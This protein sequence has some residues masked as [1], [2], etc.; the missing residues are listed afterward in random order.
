MHSRSKHLGSYDFDS[1]VRANKE[2]NEYVQIKHGRKTIDFSNPKGVKALNKALLSHFYKINYWDVPKNYLCPPV[3]G[4]A[5]YV[6]YV[7]DFLDCKFKEPKCQ[8]MNILDIGVGANCI[9][10]LLGNS[11]YG[12]NFV[13]TEIDYEAFKSARSIVAN[14]KLEDFISFRFQKNNNTI[15]RGIIEEDDFFEMTI[16]NPPFHSSEEEAKK[17]TQRKWRNLGIKKG[18]NDR[19]F[20]GNTSELWHPGG[21]KAFI[22]KM[23]YESQNYG[24]NCRWFSTLVSKK[25][26]L[27]SIYQ[28]LK[29]VNCTDYKTVEMNQGQKQ[30]RIVF[31]TFFK[32]I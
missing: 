1:L 18:A 21:E 20:G 29:T 25:K 28:Y 16:C 3:P 22:K 27:P 23:I 5:D 7:A 8:E 12:W 13:G 2:L 14:N 32:A 11:E 10:P 24:N 9:F 26:N 30:S 19:N 15:F 17:S 4:R 6:H 31:W